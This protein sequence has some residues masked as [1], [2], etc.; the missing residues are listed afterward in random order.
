MEV[1]VVVISVEEGTGWFCGCG[2]SSDDGIV[3][4]LEGSESG[5]RELSND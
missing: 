2:G 3:G 4:G 1:V 5:L